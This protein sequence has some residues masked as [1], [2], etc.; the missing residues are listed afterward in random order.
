MVNWDI[1]AHL[2]LVVSCLKLQP[3]EDV[4]AVS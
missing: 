2:M 1:V 4:L 3:S